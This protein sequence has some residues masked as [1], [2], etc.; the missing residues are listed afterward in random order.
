MSKVTT[1]FEAVDTGMVAT[2]NKIERETKSMS[3]ATE[4]AEKSVGLSFGAMAKAGAGLAIGIGAIKGAFAALTGT[5]DNFGQALDMGGR[6]SDLSARTGET[7]GNLLLLERSFDNTGVGADKVG[8]SINKLQKF[9]SDA[10]NGS[11]KNI[12]AL[13]RLGL[14]YEQLANLSPTDQLGM[15]AEKITAINSPTERAAAAMG[16]FGRSGGQLLPMLQNFSGEIANAQSELGSMTGIMDSKSGVFDAVSDK[17]TVIKGKFTEFAVG[18]LSQVTPA[19]EMF[20][21][22]LAK[23]DAAGIGA[24]LTNGAT[25]FFDVLVGAFLNA[26]EAASMLGTALMYA[27]KSFGN[28]IVN[29]IIDAGNSIGVM[30]IGGFKIAVNAFKGMFM[31]AVGTGITFLAE[32]MVS[33]A[34]LFGDEAEKKARS[35]A[36]PLISSVKQGAREYAKEMQD[37]NKKIGEQMAEITS[38]TRASTKDFFGA[39][40]ELD[41]LAATTKKFE[42]SGRNFREGL[43]GGGDSKDNNPLAP[44]E[45]SMARIEV[46]MRKAGDDLKGMKKTAEEIS[47]IQ[48]LMNDLTAAKISK[49]KGIDPLQAD[50]KKQIEKG[51]FRQAERTIERIQRKEEEAA[52]RINEK[53]VADR[54]SI[55]DIAKEEGIDTFGKTQAELRKEILEKRKGK[56]PEELRKE[57]EQKEGK[58]KEPAKADPLL[59]VVKMIKDLVAKIEPKLPTHALAL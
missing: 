4:K 20:T 53:G 48:K 9:M 50:L 22:M 12:E 27:V 1:T 47:M 6:L 7:A 40:G 8:T 59:E 31:Q 56:T 41:K 44:V 52:I 10:N 46:S 35:I 24:R 36:D 37:A 19:L 25:Q 49:E 30:L 23:V 32:K 57:K 15:I 34:S 55:A 5:L 45:D 29:S 2:I 43:F 13:G 54:R 21:T 39:Q 16:I 42:E 26:K 18:L 33:A 58:E 3:N 28:A 17:L 51:N 14:S 11:E 38:N